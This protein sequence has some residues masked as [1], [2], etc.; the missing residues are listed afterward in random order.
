MIFFDKSIFATEEGQKLLNEKGEDFGLKV[1]DRENYSSMNYV[2]G[3]QDLDYDLDGK[4]IAQKGLLFLL[5]SLATFFIIFIT[6]N[7][8]KGEKIFG[9]KRSQIDSFEFERGVKIT[10][11]DPNYYSKQLQA[12]RGAAGG[13]ISHV[14]GKIS[15]SVTGIQ[16]K[17][18][19][20]T[21]F[22]LKFIDENN[23]IHEVRF[24]VE[25]DFNFD[26]TIDFLTR[27]FTKESPIKKVEEDKKG[28][29]YIA[30]VCYGSYDSDEVLTF[31]RFRDEVLSN[32]FWGRNL[33]IF[34][35]LI[36]L[37]IAKWLEKKPTINNFIKV[38]MLD[39]IYRKLK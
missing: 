18:V 27:N 22:T 8:G 29:C 35:Y 24:S 16:L 25:T 13:L 36:S 19:I 3:L 10:V 11:L 7:K 12:G 1:L 39:K 32:N 21:I 26:K 17:E 6:N 20:G 23:E 9:V 2:S 4:H 33:V 15:D 37:I 30:T 38:K 28:G 14:I 31:R 34:Y 5:N